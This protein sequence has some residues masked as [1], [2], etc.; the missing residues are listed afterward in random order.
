M[1]DLPHIPAEL[2]Q[3]DHPIPSD[4]SY[5]LYSD[6]Y[7]QQSASNDA[8]EQEEEEDIQDVLK[9]LLDLHEQSKEELGPEQQFEQNY[10]T[11]LKSIHNNE[12]MQ[13]K[14]RQQIELVDKQLDIN[15]NLLV[16]YTCI[17]YSCI[18][19]SI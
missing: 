14:V 15:A 16:C 11:V 10:L 8:S 7:T 3:H 6:S 9:V 12:E 13:N 5:L 4:P 18:Y 1:S 19:F 2:F 17:I